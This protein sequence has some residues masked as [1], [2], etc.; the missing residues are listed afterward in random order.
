LSKEEEKERKKKLKFE[1]KRREKILC[2]SCVYSPSYVVQA[3][4]R[5]Q[6]TEKQERNK[7]L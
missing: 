2:K 3:A 6:K 5:K 4:M 1:Q 7:W